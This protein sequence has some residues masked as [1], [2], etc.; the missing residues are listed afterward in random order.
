MPIVICPMRKAREVS[1][2]CKSV[3]INPNAINIQA[4]KPFI[5]YLMVDMGR[6]DRGLIN[7]MH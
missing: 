6:V 4:R 3:R 1:A 5:E 7:G 2:L